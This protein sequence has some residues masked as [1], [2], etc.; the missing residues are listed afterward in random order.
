VTV[1]TGLNVIGNNNGTFSCGIGQG[2]GL[3]PYG[4]PYV[5]S[6]GSNGVRHFR[7][8]PDLEPPSITMTK[9]AA[10]ASDGDIFVAPRDGP[11]QNG[12]LI[13]DSHGKVVWFLPYPVSQNTSITN[14]R[15][16]NLYGQPALTWWQGNTDAGYGRGEGVIFD[17][18]YQ[19]IATVHAAN[20]LDADSH[21]FL[22][23]PQG[24]AYISAAWP[25]RL[26]GVTRATIDAVIQEIEVKTGLVLFEW[27]SLD[28]I[29]LSASYVKLPPKGLYDPYH[30]NSI[31]FDRSGNLVIS[32]RNTSA[33]YDLDHQTGAVL[34]TLGGKDASFKMG[35]GTSTWGQHDA[36]MQPDG[37]LTLFDDGGGPPKV[38]PYSRGIHERVD[39]THKIATLIKQYSHAPPISADFEGSMQT[40]SNGEVFLGWG[41]LPYFSEYTADGRQDFDAHFTVPT[42]SYRAYRFPWRAQ[43]PTMPAL[44]VA[45]TATGLVH[46]FASGYGA[47]DVSSWHVLGGSAPRALKSL[48]NAARRGFETRVAVHS[49]ERYFA[50]QA[51]GASGHVL[52]T[53]PASTTPSHLTI[54]GNTTWVPASGFGGVPV[55]CPTPHPCLI[56]TTVTAGRT[57]IARTGKEYVGAGGSGVVYF[58][59]SEAGSAMLAHAK[60]RTL[61][62][63]VTVRSGTGRTANA[64]LDLVQ[65]DATGAGPPRSLSGSPSL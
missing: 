43:P 44:A 3:I 40:L 37:S 54:Y 6:A 35:K 45:P 46:R 52:A 31:A 51:I 15:V 12:P 57:V 62:V 4:K 50:V 30:L 18:N 26:P 28:H 10:P 56:A 63:Q 2:S 41:E 25:V 39:T 33:V 47:T 60:S 1:W 29:P 9:D 32:M 55:S 23:T 64:R 42:A 5:V 53:S 7:S 59:L 48:G 19:Q 21:D 49:N 17:R 27:H 20:A 24:D 65:F 11:T 8:R 36:V 16:Q 58:Q 13:L 38:H 34:W 14:F 22:L 61:P